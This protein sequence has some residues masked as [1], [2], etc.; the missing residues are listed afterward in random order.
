MLKVTWR[1]LIARKV[2]LLLSGLAIVIG[3]AFVA[4]SFIFTDSL[5]GAFDDIIEGSTADVEI[6]PAGANDFDSV[7]DSRTIPA[8]VVAD[9]EKLPEVGSVHPQNGL[10]SVFVI[11]ED[12]KVVGGNGPPGLAFN[13]S[14]ATSLT[15]NPILEVV[16]GELPSAPYQIALDVDTADKA[17]YSVGD[18]VKLVTPGK[19][20][21]ME[22]TLTGLVEFGNGSG[23]NGA[24]LT[25]F[26]R[27]FMQ[28]QFFGGKDVYSTISLNAADGVSQ[29]ELRDAAQAVLPKG[30]EARTGDEYVKTNQD[31]LDEI[32]GF[33]QTFLLVFAGVSLVVGVFMIINTFSILVAQRSRELA[34]LRTLG[35]SKRQVTVSVVLEAL[36]V[37][38]VGSTIG[39]GVG[40]LLARGLAAIFGL[41]GLDLGNADYPITVPT[42]L[43]SYVVG[44]V[45]TVIAAYLPAR[46]ASAIAPIQALRDDGTLPETALRRRLIVG[47]VLVLLGLGSLTAGFA[48]DGTLGLSLIGL[49]MLLVLVGVALMSPIAAVPVIS[50]FSAPYRVFGTVGQ[51]ATQNS[52]RN[53][54]RTAATASALMVG[55]ALV[56]MISILGRS[57][58]ESTEAALQENLTSQFIVSNVVQ[59]PFSTDVATEIRKIDGV[60]AVASLRSAFVELDGDRVT[61]GAIDPAVFSQALALPLISGSLADLKSGTVIV[62]KTRA[63]SLGLKVGDSTT[64]KMQGGS[65]PLT[66]A[67]VLATT[68]VVPAEALVTFDTL[69]KG[70]IAPLDSLVLVTKDPG[71]DT[72][73]VRDEIEAVTRDLPTV[74][75]KDPEGLAAEQQGQINT[76]LN[77]IYGLLALS[78][79]IAILGVINTLSLSVIERT[80]EIGLLRAIGM[81]RRQLRRMIRLES[82]V[83]AVFGALLG[84]VLGLAFGAG[85]IYAL[86]DQGLTELSIPWFRLAIFVVAAG[87]VGVLAA[88]IP[89]RR[90][91]KL[92]VLKAIATE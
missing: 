33:I 36:V 64:L 73:T 90:A 21:T 88:Y 34:L 84:M 30:V 31:A 78:V 14:G 49:G 25:L 54:R 52:M 81:S 1:N 37:G 11:G 76:F 87:L 24:T 16:K 86:R 44:I 41:L 12:G 39:L 83:V 7:Q 61:V 91:A 9:L 27:K 53:P 66:V 5:G 35:A 48:G 19:P 42:V 38:I 13:P 68:A 58:S 51:L 82:V 69:T 60:A 22:T 57:A 32:L 29:Q 55:L 28:D 45:V 85:L 80:R 18:T 8:S 17:G 23:L 2:R 65:V 70:G 71:A 74:T 46:R 62:A 67:G 50:A 40:Y 4:G 10:Q 89:A 15:G 26:E 47:G 59:Q 63:D 20:P 56:A 6:A 75:V 72:A 43:W 79:V 77:L 92:D 3:V